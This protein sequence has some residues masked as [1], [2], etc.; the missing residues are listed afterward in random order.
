[1]SDP[2][3]DGDITICDVTAIQRHLAEMSIIPDEHLDLADTNGDEEIDITDATHLQ[4]YIDRFD[5]VVLR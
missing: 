1:M 3:L 5:G 2:D 4:R